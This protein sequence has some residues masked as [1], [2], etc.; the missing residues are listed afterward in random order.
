MPWSK[1]LPATLAA[2]TLMQGVTA[3]LWM[4]PLTTRIILTPE[5]D[6]SERLIHVWTVWEPLP[7]D[8]RTA[9]G[10]DDRRVPP[11]HAPP[12][13]RRC[14]PPPRPSPRKLED[15]SGVLPGLPGILTLR[16]FLIPFGGERCAS[17]GREEWH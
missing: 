10:A 14:A 12:C 6:Q 13:P 1:I 8:H 9:L 5:F 15:Q 7:P 3:L 2:G 11:V 16:S 4:N 17:G